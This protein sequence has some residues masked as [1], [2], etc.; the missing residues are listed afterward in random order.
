MN[1]PELEA[2][3]IVEKKMDDFLYA[4]LSFYSSDDDNDHM[5]QQLNNNHG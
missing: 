4:I 3:W 1:K 2:Q 5:T